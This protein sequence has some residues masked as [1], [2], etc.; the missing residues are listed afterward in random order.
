M[1]DNILSPE[2]EQ[3]SMPSINLP[4][5]GYIQRQDAE[6]IKYRLNVDDLITQMEHD[7]KGEHWVVE[8]LVDEKG[9]TIKDDRGLPLMQEHWK[10]VGVAKCNDYGAK[11]LAGELRS[12]VGKNSFLSTFDITEINDICL[13]FGHS[14]TYSI[15][16]RHEDYSID[17]KDFFSIINNLTNLLYISLKRAFEGGERNAISVVH[18][19]N[20]TNITGGERGRSLNPFNLIRGSG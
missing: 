16:D 12:V 9:R 1:P 8:P 4:P 10:K 6:T 19:V 17:P 5:S 15:E 20:E 13:R 3:F 18:Q 2:Q 11:A 14:L 7:L